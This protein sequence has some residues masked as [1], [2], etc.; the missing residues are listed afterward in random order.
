MKNFLKETKELVLSQG[1]IAVLAILQVSFTAKTLGPSN[2]GLIA[3]YLAIT[4]TFFRLLSSRN[5]DLVLLFVKDK[6]VK[7]NHFF[8]LDFLLGILSGCLTVLFILL[9]DNSLDLRLEEYL[10]T[11]LLY[12]FSRTFLNFSETFKGY[13]THV[14]NLKLFSY[15]E[16]GTVLLRFLL[17]VGLLLI[18]PNVEMYLLAISI[19]SVISGTTAI[20]FVKKNQTSDNVLK[21]SFKEFFE[22]IKVSFFKLRI[23]QAFGI[24]PVNLDILI[25]GS[26]LDT[27]NV[28]IY[29][30]AK[31]LIE[32]VN[33]IVVA[34]S[35]WML[36]KLKLDSNFKFGFLTK[37]VLL[38]IATLMTLFY[39]FTGERVITLL[40]SEEFVEAFQPMIIM[41]FGYLFYLTT[42]WTRHF[43]LINDAIL[44]HTK[45]RILNAI[46]FIILSILLVNNFAINGVAT[47]VSM[48]IVIQKIFE[49][50]SAYK[51]RK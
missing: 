37:K 16:S 44:S 33:Y 43:L 22:T 19:Y 3:I 50:R 46:T 11:V 13:F 17:V 9:F 15:F 20:Y 32:P 38:P 26:Y 14:G 2:Y 25:I 5:A 21:L 1:L 8:V 48:G 29:Q 45:G 31:K 30:F 34:F 49:V 6:G 40:G 4:A 12:V 24:I 23:D 10:L 28:G 7:T 47:A 51:L 39:I 27:Y 35:P 42:F 36:N 18:A 41:L